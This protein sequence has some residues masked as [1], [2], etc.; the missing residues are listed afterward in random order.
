MRAAAIG[1]AAVVQQ[2]CASSPSAVRQ[3]DDSLTTEP[4]RSPACWYSCEAGERSDQVDKPLQVGADYDWSTAVFR[5][6]RRG[7]YGTCPEYR[8][9]LYPDGRIE[10]EGKEYVAACGQRV[11]RALEAD[12][13]RLV[14]AFRAEGYLTRDLI[15]DSGRLRVSD[16]DTAITVVEIGGQRRVVWHYGPRYF[17][18]RLTR[19]E[20]LIDEVTGTRRWTTC[21]WSTPPTP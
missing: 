19:L 4:W 15:Q 14:Q 13:A 7:C 1:F 18:P 5:L 11:A 2:G 20:Q 3:H 17:G 8:V 12:R 16:Q 9:S 6:E 10:Y 21:R